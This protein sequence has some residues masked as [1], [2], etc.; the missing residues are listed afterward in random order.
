VLSC[1][2]KYTLGSLPLGPREH[3]EGSLQTGLLPSRKARGLGRIFWGNVGFQRNKL[4][5][6][7]LDNFVTLISS[8]V[9]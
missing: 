9:T 3:R 8:V 7:A 1:S 5:S 4:K 6:C 2:S